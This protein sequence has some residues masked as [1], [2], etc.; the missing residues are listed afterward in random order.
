MNIVVGLAAG[1]S[2]IPRYAARLSRALDSVSVEFPGLDLSLLTTPTG[3]ERI[4]ARTIGV[5][6]FDL[7]GRFFDQGAPRLLLDQAFAASGRCDLVHFFDVSSPLLAP[8]R[9]F[10]A[11]LHDVGIRLPPTSHGFSHLQ[12]AY[13]ERLYRW[14]LPRARRVVAVSQFAKDEAVRH[15][16]ADGERI[17]VIH[18]GPG[19]AKSFPA[20]NSKPRVPPPY[21]LFVGNLT[22]SKNL[23]F[24]IRAYE[25]ANVSA[26]LVLAGRPAED[27]AALERLIHESPR[28]DTIHV[29]VDA[30]DE[31]VDRLYGSATALALPSR[32][33]GFAFTPLEAMARDCPVL[34]SRIPAVEEVSGSGALMLPLDDEAA[35]ADAIRRIVAD[36]QLRED[37]RERGRRT[38]AGYSWEKTARRLCE[39]FLEVARPRRK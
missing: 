9:P 29:V 15:F 18:S 10:V 23:P 20:T 38:V 27:P 2:G 1:H 26:G 39:L 11:T 14:V 24:L 25:R 32:Y 8:S 7:A 4:G 19:F 34:A 31:D 30:S 3:A 37:L 5:R 22:A 36:A 13:K 35:W 16:A 12:R 6:Q 17:T 33:E 28:R 21:V